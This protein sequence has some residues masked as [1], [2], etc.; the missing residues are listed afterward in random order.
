MNV[1]TIRAE[2]PAIGL[3]ARGVGASA[4]DIIYFDNP[5]GTQVSRRVLRRMQEA[6]IG[7]NAN[8]GGMFETS[9]AAEA[10]VD[11][12]HAAMADF[13]NGSPNE[14][15]FGQNMTTLTFAMSRTIGR[16][17]KAGDEILLTRMEHDANAAPWLMLAEEK[18]LVVRWLDFDPVSFEFDLT[19]L[20]TLVTDRLKLAAINYASNVIGTI[21]DVA[22]IARRVK[23]V[24]ALVYVD[25]VQF[26]P[27]GVIDVKALG[28]DF[29][30]CSSYKFY[31]PHQGILWGRREVLDRLTAY[32]VRP[33]PTEGPGK[34]ETGTASREALAGVLGALEHYQWVGTE[35]GG[36]GAKTSPR[37]RIIAGIKTIDAHEQAITAQLIDGLSQIKGI[38]I[39]G[40]TAR[41][42]MHRR[43]PT[44]SFTHL[45]F[46]PQAICVAMAKDG[47]S[48]WQGHNYG[49]EPV[50]RLGLIDRGGVVRIG[51]GQYNT[52]DEVDFLVGRLSSWIGKNG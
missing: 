27:H 40:I 29:L 21:N 14:V 18:G 6:M 49:V 47:I 10:M 4:R 8:L 26:A 39:Q 9:I 22:A 35:Y 28:C 13:F 25:A 12:A 42:A 46:D 50:K 19:Q 2:F 52:K 36:A 17:L 45:G 43:V 3:K 33:A 15:I 11:Q 16:D 5:A 24:G 1:D 30:V 41:T 32:R 23:E 34:F 31:G 20:E 44:I 48:L 7:L 38:A 37:A 51:L